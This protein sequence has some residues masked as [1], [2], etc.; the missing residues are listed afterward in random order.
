[1]DFVLISQW[2]GHAN[3]DTTMRYARTDLDLKRQAF[4]QIFPDALGS[5]KSR[6]VPIVQVNPLD[7][8]RNL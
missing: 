4:C 8:L 1:M 5:S 2:L 6:A 3:L 7:W